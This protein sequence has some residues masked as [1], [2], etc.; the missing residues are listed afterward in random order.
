[1]TA[2]AETFPARVM[3]DMYDAVLVLD[4]QGYVVFCNGP[5]TRMLELSRE[6][7]L[8]RG[9]ILSLNLDQSYNDDFNECIMNALYHKDEAQIQMVRYMAPSGKKYVFRMSSSYLHDGDGELVITLSDETDADVYRR[10]YAEASRTFSVFLHAFCVWI[11]LYALWDY[12]GR[13]FRPQLLT[14]DVEILGVVMFLYITHFTKMSKSD[15]GLSFEDLGKK[16]RSGVMVSLGCAAFL[17]LLKFVLR[18][19]LPN[20]FAPTRPFFD[21]AAFDLSHVYYI[22]TAAIQEFL[23]RS[24]IQGNL[25]RIINVKHAGAV[26][27]V[28]SSLIFAALHVHLGFLFM[29][30]A[31]ILAGL[32]GILYEKYRSVYTLWIVHYTFGVVGMLLHLV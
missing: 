5:A 2:A 15:L 7:Q 32:E 17:F 24:V 14:L 25:R 1:M 10:K 13:P 16:L 29:I 28:L 27:I 30:G 19:F 8:P 22:V 23:A 11:I 3:R 18:L 6:G 12:L 26:S 9:A 31:A 21:I 20:S 4:R